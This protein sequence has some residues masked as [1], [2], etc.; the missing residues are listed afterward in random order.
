LPATGETNYPCR[1]SGKANYAARA[2]QS[3]GAAPHL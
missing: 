1:A 3:D 2:K